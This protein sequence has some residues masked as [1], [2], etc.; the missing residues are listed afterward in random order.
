[1]LGLNA[2]GLGDRLMGLTSRSCRG[3]YE[4]FVPSDDDMP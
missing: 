2:D 3:S 4:G 1:M